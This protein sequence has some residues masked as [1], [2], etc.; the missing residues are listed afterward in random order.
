MTAMTAAAARAA[1]LVVD[2]EPLIFAD[3]LAATL[4]GDQ[5]GPLLAYHRGSPAHDV[6]AVA[7]ATVTTRSRFTEERLA[8]AARRGVGQYLILGAGLDSFAWRSPLAARVRVI[9]ADHP[10][11]QRWKHA[12]LAEA[13]MTARGDVRYAGTDLEAG[14][15]DAALTTAGFD[16]GQPALISWL[17]VI[18][19]LSAD[20]I[21]S[22]LATLSRCARG[23]ELVAEYL[24]PDDLRDGLGRGYAQQVAPV[25]AQWGE[26]WRTCLRPGEMGALLAAHGFALAASVPQRETVPDPLW[27]RTDALRPA[28]LG[29]LAH[30][31]RTGPGGD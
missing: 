13:G 31:R 20:A 15:L 14:T 12:R 22:T 23:T 4:L 6:L 30:A 9:E 25:A 11:A 29:W 28:R 24:V 10:G 19:Y 27:D 16:F 3:S 18:M 8:E 7:R 26:P 1:H 21:T 17:G 2:H 5:A